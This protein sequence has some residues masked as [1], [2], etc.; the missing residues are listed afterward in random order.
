MPKYAN[1]H[2]PSHFPQW[3]RFLVKEI[4]HG[5][6]G[7]RSLYAVWDHKADAPATRVAYHDP[8]YAAHECIDLMYHQEYL[9]AISQVI[10]H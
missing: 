8:A 4:H 9:A 5:D 1:Q 2:Q 3:G 7:Q 10:D 6:G